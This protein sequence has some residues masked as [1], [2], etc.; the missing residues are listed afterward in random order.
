MISPLEIKEK[1]AKKYIPYLQSWMQGEPF[2]PIIIT[3]NKDYKNISSYEFQKEIN[4]LVAQ[5]HEKKGY[6]FKIEY[7][8]IKTKNMGTQDVPHLIYFD[9]EQDFLQFLDKEK[10]VLAF[11]NHYARTI[12]LFPALGE[13]LLRYPAKVIQYHEQ[14]G[15]ILAVCHYFQQN[16]RPNRYIRELPVKVHTKFIEAH[17]TILQSLL[18]ILMQDHLNGSE[19]A[20]EKRFHLKYAEPQVRFKILDPAISQ[21]YFSGLDDLEIPI[22]QFERL[23]L[24]LK[25]AIIVENKTS[26]YTTLTLPKM[27][28]TIAVFGSGYKIGLLQ[29]T[30]WLWGLAL[31][32]WGDLDAQGFEILSQFRG[33]FP[34]TQ[35]VMMDRGTF[36]LF[37]EKDAGTVST[38]SQELNLTEA[39]AALYRILKKN[40]WRLE[41]EKIPWDYVNGVF[42]Y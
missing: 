35:S 33:Y 41:Q 30:T 32:Y 38:V 36:E 15:D 21:A 8:Q 22:S 10:E 5:S 11:K 31:L 13:W 6:G 18:D 29:H 25:R 27:E 7:R 23:Q 19:T 17:K 16:P 12:S 26:L 1:A 40:N 39:E 9:S 20:F 34:H 28:G 4:A 42:N 37:F 2:S 24:P 14:W 3:G